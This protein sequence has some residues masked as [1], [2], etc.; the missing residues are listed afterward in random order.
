MDLTV[1]AGEVFGFLGPNGSGKT[2]TIRLLTGFI[3]PTAGRAA[4]FGMD[5]WGDRVAIAQGLGYLPDSGGLD[6]SRSGRDALDFLAALQVRP[7]ALQDELLDKLEFPRS[8]LRRRVKTYSQGMRQKLAIVQALQ[9]DPSLV[10]LD[11]PTSGLDPLMQQT[12]FDIVEDLRRRGR[13]VFMSS[14]ALSEVERLCDRVGIVREG[15][16]VAVERVETLRARRVRQMEVTFAGEPP[17]DGAKLPGVMD[18]AQDGRVWRLRVQGNV[19]PLVRELAKFELED[20]V[21]EQARL[22][23]VFLAYYQSEEGR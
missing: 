16:L 15:E 11:E 20:L 23:D 10:I 18:I 4:V 1:Y 13:T 22:E 9:H 12:F 3:R 6:D 14:H 19:T 21:F 17:L 5:A 2:T 8:A 7:P